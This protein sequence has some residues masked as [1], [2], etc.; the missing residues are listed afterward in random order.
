MGK[1]CNAMGII[2]C[3]DFGNRYYYGLFLGTYEALN[4]GGFW[5]WD[6]AA[7]NAS[8]IPWL[9]LIAGV[10]VMIAFKAAG[11][12]FFTASCAN[13]SKLCIGIVCFIPYKERYFG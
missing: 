9:T 3:N 1:T 12:A 4:F 6:P 2:C 8:I 10:H 13:L 5:A 11:H 7:E